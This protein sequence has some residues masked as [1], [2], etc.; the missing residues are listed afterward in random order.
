MEEEVSSQKKRALDKDDKEGMR[1]ELEEIRKLLLE[2]SDDQD[3]DV[4]EKTSTD[5]EDVEII[6]V[7]ENSPKEPRENNL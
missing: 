1:M 7:I 5:T 4:I 2:S 3:G 6:E